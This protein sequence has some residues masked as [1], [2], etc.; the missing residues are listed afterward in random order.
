MYN[1]LSIVKVIGKLQ[2]RWVELFK[3]KNPKKQVPTNTIIT[4]IT[5]PLINLSL[6]C[7]NTTTSASCG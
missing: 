4:E 6:K 5:K 2:Y 1:E 3:S 7:K